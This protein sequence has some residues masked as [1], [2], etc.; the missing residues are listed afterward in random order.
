MVRREEGEMSG[1]MSGE[2]A[3]PWPDRRSLSGEEWINPEGDFIQVP[4]IQSTT[5]LYGQN[6]TNFSVLGR[7]QML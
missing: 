2:L 1:E 7:R 6:I 3:T 5:T 4:Y